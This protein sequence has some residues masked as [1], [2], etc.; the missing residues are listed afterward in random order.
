MYTFYHISHK[1]NKTLNS[2]VPGDAR[3]N[4]VNIG[5]GNG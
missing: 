5:S 3:Q 1:D 2:L 4:L